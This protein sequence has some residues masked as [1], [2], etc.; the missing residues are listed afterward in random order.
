MSERIKK[1]RELLDARGIQWY[2]S[3]NNLTQWNVNGVN[4]SA[5]A[6]WPRN[7]ETQTKIIVHVSGLTPEQAVSLSVER[8]CRAIPK[9]P[10]WASC[11]CSACGGELESFNKF[12]P[13]CGAR[14]M[15]E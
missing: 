7:D 8:M 14:V 13:N 5:A 15:E 9:E 2:I 12:C 11:E 4:F 6:L 1:L 3:G 10:R